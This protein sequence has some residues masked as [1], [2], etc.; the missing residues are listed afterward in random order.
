MDIKKLT[1]KEL[2]ILRFRINIWQAPLSEY[3]L[4]IIREVSLICA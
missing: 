3:Q 2:E 4:S 1:Q